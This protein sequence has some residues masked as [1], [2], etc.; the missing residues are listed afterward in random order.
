MLYVGM[1]RLADGWNGKGRKKNNMH[2]V[3]N[4]IPRSTTKKRLAIKGQ[5]IIV[6]QIF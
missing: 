1:M 4:R 5:L 6:T 3:M 2:I